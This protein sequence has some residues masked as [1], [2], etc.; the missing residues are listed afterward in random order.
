MTTEKVNQKLVERIS[1]FED[2][3]ETVIAEIDQ[4][5]GSRLGLQE[6]LDSIRETL[7]A[8]YGEPFINNADEEIKK[9]PFWSSGEKK[10]Y[11]AGFWT[12]DG[13]YHNA[14]L[15]G[16]NTAEAKRFAKKG[17]GKITEFDYIEQD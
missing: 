1:S 13:E 14:I 16:R 6:S 17:W 11:G 4:T 2:A 15:W 3:V 8:A 7:A 10:K 5:D 12:A 9:N